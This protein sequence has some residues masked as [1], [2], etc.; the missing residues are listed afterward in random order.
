MFELEKIKY[1]EIILF[2]LICSLLFLFVLKKNKEGFITQK[3]DIVIY[4]ENDIF[5]DFYSKIYDKLLFDEPKLNFEINYIFQAE[6]QS[7]NQNK[8]KNYNVLDIGCG[9]GHHINKITD[10]NIKC[11]GI[12]N[13]ISMIAKSRNQFPKSKFK[14]ANAMN[15]LE[16]PE[17]SFSHILCLYFTIYYFKDK[18]H[19]LEN[20]FHWLRPNGVLILHVVNIKKFNITPPNSKPFSKSHKTAN[21]T[22]NQ[23]IIKFDKFK[24]RCNFISDTNINFNTLRLDEPNV[25]FKEIFKFEDTNKVRINE[26]KLYMSSQN[27]IINSALEVGFMLKSYVEIKLDTCSY[28]YLYTLEKPN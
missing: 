25:I 10:L 16:F 4:T 17:R 1:V 23:N 5:D 21:Q 7:Q 15:S 18:R 6:A 24:Y 11:I 2:V 27:S 9:T 8:M 12:D 3:Q 20:C 26:H 14:L 22:P 13:S 28:N 19:L